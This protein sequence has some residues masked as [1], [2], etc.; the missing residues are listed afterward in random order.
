MVIFWEFLGLTKLF[1]LF[2]QT[3]PQNSMFLNKQ[4]TPILK[5]NPIFGRFWSFFGIIWGPFLPFLNITSQTL[6]F[7]NKKNLWSH[8][9]WS[10]VDFCYFLG[11]FGSDGT[12]LPFWKLSLRVPCFSKKKKSS[13]PQLQSDLGRFVGWF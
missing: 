4:R 2:L 13:N 5:W 3:S 12:S 9:I 6:M 1:W 11:F 10:W 8:K 7:L